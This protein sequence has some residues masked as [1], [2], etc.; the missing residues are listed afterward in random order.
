ML[1]S[2]VALLNIAYIFRKTNKRLTCF[3]ELSNPFLVFC[4]SRSLST[5][6]NPKHFSQD[7]ILCYCGWNSLCRLR[8]KKDPSLFTLHSDFHFSASISQ[9]AGYYCP[10]RLTV[11]PCLLVRSQHE[12]SGARSADTAGYSG[13]PAPIRGLL[14]N[15]RHT[16][17]PLAGRQQLWAPEI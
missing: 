13:A 17:F 12:L 14:G 6:C 8:Q 16:E 10:Q 1:T 7:F 2:N 11:L 5:S 9:G 15:Q 3:A 4:L